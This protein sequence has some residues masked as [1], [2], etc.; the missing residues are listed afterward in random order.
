MT[1]DLCKLWLKIAAVVVGS[2]APVFFLGSMEPTAES[3]RF[4]M[5]LLGW[6]IDGQQRFDDPTVRFLSALAAGSIANRFSRLR[7]RL[8]APDQVGGVVLRRSH[9]L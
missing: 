5:D 3:A 4:T 6:P 7:T 9:Q 8:K 1:H 2:F